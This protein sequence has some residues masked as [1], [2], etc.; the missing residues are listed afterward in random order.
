MIDG[1]TECRVFLENKYINEVFYEGT[2]RGRPC[3]VKCSTKCPWSIGNEYELAARLFACAP[4]VVEEPLARGDDFGEGPAGRVFARPCAYVV[5]AKIA[6][7]SLTQLLAQGLASAQA[8]SFA[9]DIRQ[10][11]RALRETGILHRDLFADN[12]LLGDDGHLKA[13]D[14]QL[15]IDRN[16]PRED[17][18]V[19]RH[20]KFRYVVFGVN[21][22]L[23]LGVWNDFHALGKILA[24][25]PQTETVRAVADELAA[26]EN[27]MAYADPPKGLVRLGLWLYGCSLRLQMILRGK[28]HR[29]Y[30]Q[31][32][33][34]WR[35]VRGE[36]V[37]KS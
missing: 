5:T 19:L 36:F 35:T 25:F 3:V 34:R 21:R 2:Y 23:G 1:L 20:W 8:D 30:V 32:E 10:L 24:Q 16:R 13:I 11:A 9:V 17:P 31:L 12:L 33:N 26:A 6:G 4:T 22:E 29:K 7:P 27:E 18:W 37:Q 15:A 28:R 14:F